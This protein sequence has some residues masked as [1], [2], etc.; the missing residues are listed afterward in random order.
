MYVC[1]KENCKAFRKVKNLK[2]EKEKSEA[3][4][5][6]LFTDG[7]WSIAYLGATII[8]LFLFF[9][10]NNKFSAINF[11]LCF[12]P[13]F[14]VIYFLLSFLSFHYVRP[15]VNYKENSKVPEISLASYRPNLE[16]EICIN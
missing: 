6:E 3:L 10:F 9:F 8:T 11:S 12:I 16:Q 14:L 5:H 4:K 13:S 7:L 2:S 15:I 1:D